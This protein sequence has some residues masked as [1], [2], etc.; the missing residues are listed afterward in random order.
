M[1]WEVRLLYK[2][3][4]ERYNEELVYWGILEGIGDVE[5]LRDLKWL[6]SLNDVDMGIGF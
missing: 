5:R 1:F 3:V 2:E 4:C 6:M